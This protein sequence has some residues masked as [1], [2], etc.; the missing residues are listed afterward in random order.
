MVS[1]T[2]FSDEWSRNQAFQ[3][4]SEPYHLFNI[5]SFPRRSFTHQQEATAKKQ[6]SK[7]LASLT[8]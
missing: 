7:K 2:T 8:S 1:I 5:T 3:D 4:N 6:L